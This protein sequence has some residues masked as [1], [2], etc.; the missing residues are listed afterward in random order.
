MGY[1]RKEIFNKNLKIMFGFGYF[2]NLR[3]QDLKKLENIV[4]LELERKSNY[5]YN[6][7]SKRV[8]N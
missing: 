1:Q 4:K 6:W 8:S 5:N 7:N 2:K 3:I